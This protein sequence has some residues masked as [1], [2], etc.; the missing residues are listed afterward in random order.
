M[1][2]S[3]TPT[4]S[5]CFNLSSQ[6]YLQELTNTFQPSIPFKSTQPLQ[7][8]EVRPSMNCQD[9]QGLVYVQ[10]CQQILLKH[11]NE[12]ENSWWSLLGGIKENCSS[13]LKENI[14]ISYRATIPVQQLK[15][16]H[17]L[18]RKYKSS[19]CLISPPNSLKKDY[20]PSSQGSP[21]MSVFQAYFGKWISDDFLEYKKLLGA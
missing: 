3:N 1:L 10:C 11:Q 21:K 12:L 8:L 17:L 5:T 13:D 14:W 9:F 7:Y 15:K 4:T 20:L 18:L 19:C 2:F 16:Q 6:G